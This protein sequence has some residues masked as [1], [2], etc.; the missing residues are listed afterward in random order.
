MYLVVITMTALA[1]YRSIMF[2]KQLSVFTPESIQGTVAVA[3]PDKNVRTHDV[4]HDDQITALKELTD[5]SGTSKPDCPAPLVP[6]HH[7]IAEPSSVPPQRIPRLIHVAWVRGTT[8]TPASQC[9]CLPPAMVENVELWKK[10]FPSYS[11]FFH[12]DEAVDRLL[13]QDLPEFPQLKKIL[14]SCIKFGGAVKVDIWRVLVLF[15]YGGIY[16]DIDNG[17][18]VEFTQDLIQS[19]ILAFFL[20]DSSNRPSQWMQAM[21]PRHPIAYFTM[22]EILTRVLA[23]ENVNAIRPV[24]LTGPDSLR[25]GYQKAMKKENETEN[26][27]ADGVHHT[28][29]GDTVRKISNKKN[30]TFQDYVNYLRPKYLKWMHHGSH[31]EQR[32]ILQQLNTTHWTHAVGKTRAK[33]SGG[34]CWEHLFKNDRLD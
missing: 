34:S 16:S 31:Q 2:S 12:T 4:T 30:E 5:C 19:N 22:L 21:E 28:K 15:L 10:Q 6:L 14:N 11:F 27:F 7:K 25:A 3:C 8:S 33:G 24:F 18:G 26:I 1:M 13:Q 17:P 29:F 23:M 20:S 9:R 32:E